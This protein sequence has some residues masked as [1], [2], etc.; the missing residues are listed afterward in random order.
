MPGEACSEGAHY[1]PTTA[2]GFGPGRS[3]SHDADAPDITAPPHRDPGSDVPGVNFLGFG[4][5]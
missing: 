4:S 2:A 5:N 3:H 1:L